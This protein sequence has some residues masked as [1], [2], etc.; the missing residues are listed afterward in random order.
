MLTG[1]THRPALTA[2]Q[3]HRLARWL[4]EYQVL[5]DHSWGLTDTVVLH[6]RHHGG[7]AIVKAAQPGDRHIAREINAHRRWTQP[8]LSAGSIGRMLH[9]AADLSLLVTEYL[10]GE[11]VQTLPESM[12]SPDV[13]RQAGALLAAFHHQQSRRSDSYLADADRQ[14]LAWLDQPHRIP[15]EQAAAARAAVAA[16]RPEPIE[17]VPTHGDWQARNWLIDAGVLRVIDLGRADWRPRFTDLARLARR[18][19][20]GRAD[21]A[22][23]FVTG[24]GTDPREGRLWRAAQLRE[25]IG[26]AVWAY[27]VGD[28]P[29]EQ[30]GLRTIERIVGRC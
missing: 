23:A 29:F 25:G 15:A 24:Y 16:H 17:L 28:E 5:T 18:E 22:D 13:H 19:W 27:R 7:E 30:E 6:V 12:Y 9:A 21:L 26:T 14:A 10:P 1:V 20:D 2:Q 4:G 8:W 3:C 11:L